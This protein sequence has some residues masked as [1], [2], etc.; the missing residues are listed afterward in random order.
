MSLVRY[1][2]AASPEAALAAPLGHAE[3]ESDAA[4]LAGMDVAFVSHDMGP[5]FDS[6]EAAS[7][8]W[9]DLLGDPSPEAAWHKIRET[10][11]PVSGRMPGPKRLTP[12]FENGK[13]WPAALPRPRT[14]WRLNITYW[15]PKVAQAD[16]PA[17]ETGVQARKLRRDPEAEQLDA[18]TLRALATQPLRA[19]RL[20]KGLDIGLFEVRAPE[21]PDRL[22]ADE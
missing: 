10:M 12:S 8:A 4:R 14:V 20:Q 3:R 18:A 2:V 6:R 19:Q 17:A 9:R 22:I 13:R 1:P 7:E 16:L 21:D 15:R 5:E 11:A